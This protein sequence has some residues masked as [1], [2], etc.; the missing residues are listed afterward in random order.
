MK[1]SILI[2]LAFILA[3]CTAEPTELDYNRLTWDK[4]NISHYRFE[5]NISC[6][7]AFNEQMPLTVEVKDGE[8]VSM[9]TVDGTPVAV[10]DP[11][12]EF[13]VGLGTMDR[14]FAE[15]ESAMSSKDAGDIIVKYDASLGYPTEASIDY[16]K[17]AVDDELYITVAGFEALP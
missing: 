2:L 6:F 13:F 7:C 16:I 14:L 5:L 12:Y 17:A 15:L 3:A 8:V 9:A 1:R 4:A 11:N 10:S